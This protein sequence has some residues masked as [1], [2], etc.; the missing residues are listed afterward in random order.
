MIKKLCSIIAILALILTL[1]SCATQPP[2]KETQLNHDELVKLFSTVRK[3][4]YKNNRGIGILNYQP[5]GTHHFEKGNFSD[6]GNYRIDGD[7]MCGKWQKIRSGKEV[8]WNLYKISENTF[9]V[10]YTNGKDGG[11]ITFK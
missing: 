8:C 9:Q 10:I 4:E 6:T 2:P 3:A 1:Q 5:N 7:K 11:I